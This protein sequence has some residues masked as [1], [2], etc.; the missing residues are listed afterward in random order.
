MLFCIKISELFQRLRFETLQVW[1][2]GVDNMVSPGRLLT[3]SR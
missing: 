1:D 3:P 2:N